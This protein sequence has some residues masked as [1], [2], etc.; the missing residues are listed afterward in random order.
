MNSSKTL[1]ALLLL[2]A[3]GMRATAAMDLYVS[4]T[5]NDSN[6]G[7]K[8]APV[9]SL[10]RVQ[11]LA[12]SYAGTEP[13][14][15]H[16]ADG[17]Y[18][19]PE[20][21]VF[22]EA[23]SGSSDAPVR[24]QADN[25]GG[26]VLSGGSRL[27]LTW[28]PYR[29]GIFMAQTQPGLVIDQLFV[30]G[31]N[32]R[33]ARYPNF[34]AT[35]KTEAYQGFA[36]DAFSQQRAANWANPQGGYIHAM[37]RARWGG[38][39][40]RITGK[41]DEGEVIYEG[42]WQNNRQMGM[43]KEF[44]MVENIFE[45]L[46]GPNEWYHHA[47]ANTLYYQPE[48]GTDLAN[49]T[50]E[51]VRL[52]HLIEFRGD[53]PH[54]A[55]FITLSGFVIR[56]AARTFMLTMEP[57]LRSDWTIYR[58][59]AFLLTGTENVQLLDCE[60]D[61]VGGNAI[62]ASNYNRRLLVKGC[63]IHDTGASGICF[64]G[65]PNAVRDP[66]FQYGEKND[67]SKIDRT[68]GPKTNNYPADSMVADCLI[69]GIGRVE[70]QPAGVQIE[71]ARR[72]TVRDCSIYDC[73]RAGINIGDGAWGGHLIERC[74]VFDTVQETHDHGSFNSWG[75][76][77]Y[78][79]SDRSA[80]Q[81]AIDEDPTLPF[82]D[83]VETTVIR[84]SRWRC[85]HGWDIDLDDGSSNYDIYNNLLLSG[86][87]KLREGFRR[88]AWNNITVN[89]GFH[90]HVW[91]NHS[92][93]E[94]YGNLFMAAAR[95][96]R[97]PNDNAKGKRIDGNLFYSTD[98]EAKDR[99]AE[100]GWDVNSIAADPV[101]VDP[102]RGDF[103]VQEGSPALAI[104]FKN[105]P[106]DQF[107]VKKPSLKAIAAAPVIPSLEVNAASPPSRADR[108]QPSRV[109]PVFWLGAKVQSLEG[110]AFSAFGVSQEDGGVVMSQISDNCDAAKAGLMEGDL[111]QAINAATVK[112]VEDLLKTVCGVADEPLT[113]RVIRNQQPIEVKLTVGA[114]WVVETAEQGDAFSK[115]PLPKQPAGTINANQLP[116]DEPLET[117][118]DGHLD[119]GYGPVFANQVDTGI[120]RLD[121]GQ[122]KAVSMISTWSTNKN[123]NRGPQKMTLYGSHATKDPGWDLQDRSQFVPLASIDTS[124]RK[125]NSYNATSLR[126][127]PGQSLGTFRWIVWQ[128][129]PVTR[130][131]EN[132]AFQE[133]HVE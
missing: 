59:G 23:D 12:R 16:V 62:F 7:T 93:D 112:T 5:G 124:S 20:T 129:S 68:P 13:V 128:V 8:R 51:V 6:R 65:D 63:H 111:V 1:V 123:L 24:Y 72:I 98:A 100:F 89:N 82:L 115:I 106:M 86:G 75:R 40:Y 47:E 31:K 50:V 73:A 21:L 79:R 10:K 76:D 9:A 53:E 64:V 90:P 99:Y 87:L 3:F 55:K 85:D 28:K 116:K 104:G 71:M 91:Y 69:H 97:M 101:F 103:R 37:H 42:G 54:P 117:L 14:T 70:R 109:M 66:L 43:H 78:W 125:T 132:T 52:R 48:P 121:L 4:P 133:L 60:F 67:L 95:G 88:R 45:E 25:E 32:Q 127:R 126:A 44:R 107:G 122:P 33:M 81:T 18:Y 27:E 35:K 130:I 108:S 94:V 36:A 77:R 57:M 39:H 84:N 30:D 11:T 19:L 29:D 102:L 74:D 34:D 96:A 113:V 49:A 56:H 114:Y 105:F 41:N 83:A 38:Y 110:E 61:Q 58:G 120:Y 17:V 92:G 119:E 131:G 46:D 2:I 22:T 118:V 26:A 80:S 15:V